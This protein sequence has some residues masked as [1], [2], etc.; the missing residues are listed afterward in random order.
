MSSEFIAMAKE[1]RDF[2]ILNDKEVFKE[3]T[4]VN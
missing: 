1:D 4:Q 3:I 2:D